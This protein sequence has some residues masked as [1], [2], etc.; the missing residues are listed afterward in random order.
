MTSAYAAFL[1]ART[2]A[3]TMASPPSRVRRSDSGTVRLTS[4]ASCTSSSAEVSPASLGVV[5]GRKVR[6]AS[7][8]RTSTF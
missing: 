1:K 3:G 8:P 4:A 2:S 6:R 5:P 7:S